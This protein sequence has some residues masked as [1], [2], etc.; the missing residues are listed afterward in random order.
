MSEDPTRAERPDAYAIDTSDLPCARARERRRV[1]DS[2]RREDRAT[3]PTRGRITL[4][5]I[6]FDAETHDAALSARQ[7]AMFH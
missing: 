7:G 2:A 5:D 6:Q 3:L 4:A 1:R